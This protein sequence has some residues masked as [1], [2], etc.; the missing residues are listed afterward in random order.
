M[1]RSACLLIALAATAIV[2]LQNLP[3]L[4]AFVWPFIHG[5]GI[6]SVLA[7]LP[8]AIALAVLWT[9]YHLIR[10]TARS[11]ATLLV[12]ALAI[13]I[14]VLNEWLLPATPL[15]TWADQR[16]LEG[17]R[18]LDVRDEPLLSA[19]GNPIGVR[20]SFDAVVPRSGAYLI[21]AATLSSA[22]GDMIWP[23]HFGHS[24]NRR[25][26]PAP[27]PQHDSPYDIFQK[28]VVYSFRQDMLPNFIRYDDD[29]KTLCLAEVR[30][31]YITEADF[32]SA[33]GANRD[34]GLRTEIHVNGEYYPVN[35]VAAEGVTSRRYDL[36]AIYATIAKEGGGRC[37]Q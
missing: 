21:S 5:A 10:K 20:I 25:V 32:L 14:V 23:L 36:Q 2:C 15:K 33:L 6:L 30:T 13:G 34:I 12:A 19:R 18:I 24:S 8:A 7:F 1:R 27:T 16:A 35:V 29:T 22:S 11:R 37:P 4:A 17:V 31:K 28:D 26:Q 9:G 3:S